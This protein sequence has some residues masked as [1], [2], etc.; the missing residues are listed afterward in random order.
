MPESTYICMCH[1]REI[2]QVWPA[3]SVLTVP[4][5]HQVPLVEHAVEDTLALR[6]QE[7]DEGYEGPQPSLSIQHGG[8][9]SAATKQLMST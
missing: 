1:T 3:T 8:L 9:H 2:W 7:L 6:L 4:V 5:L